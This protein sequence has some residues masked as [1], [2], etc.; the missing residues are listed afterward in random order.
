MQ[1]NINHNNILKNLNLLYIE[2][3]E[4]IRINIKKVLLLLC[5]N[6]FDAANTEEANIIFENQR[7]DIIISDINLPN[8]N[9][10]DYIKEVRKKDKTIPVILL[11]AYTDT[12]YLLEATKLKLVDYLTKPVDFKT[13]NNALHKSVEEILD[14]SRYLILFQ[15]NIQYNVLHK[16]LIDLNTQK[17]LLLTSKELDLLSFLIKN[18]NR[19]VSTDELKSNVWED[20][21]EATD[22]ALK[23]LLN[24]VRKKIGKESI[25]NISGVGYRLNF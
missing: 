18:S 4:N 12:K 13:L 9:G 20:C 22:S 8:T 17:E 7:I 19:I 6:V 15:N 2:D 5:E 24:K 11:S 16:T 3:E 23:N 14:N 1:K 10:I 25:I 21:F